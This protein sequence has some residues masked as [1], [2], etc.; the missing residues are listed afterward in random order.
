MSAVVYMPKEEL[1]FMLMMM[2]IM[3]T[4][5]MVSALPVGFFSKFCCII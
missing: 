1:L 3:M 4:M 5:M 2:M